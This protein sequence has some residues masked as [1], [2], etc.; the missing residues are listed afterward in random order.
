[1]TIT[2][3]LINVCEK[4]RQK[5]F[6]SEENVKQEIVEQ[7]LFSLGW[8]V[9][10]VSIVAREFAM[11][12]R[13]VDYALFHPPKKPLIFIEV[14][15]VGLSGGADRQLFEYAFHLGVPMAILTDG[16]EWSFYL[17]AQQGR[18]DERRVYKL[19]LLERSIEEAAYRLERYLSYNSICSGQALKNA[20][21]DYENVTRDRDIQATLPKAWIAL[22][23][24]KDSLVLELLADKV[25]DLCGYKPNVAI[26]ETFLKEQAKDVN[27]ERNLETM[28]TILRQKKLKNDSK[29]NIQGD[30]NQSENTE[31]QTVDLQHSENSES[32]LD[33]RDIYNKCIQKIELL[34]KIN[35]VRKG[36]K[37]C[38][39][40]DQE[41]GFSLCI[42]KIYKEKLGNKYWFA[43][44][45]K[46]ENYLKN[47]KDS[48]VVYICGNE[49][50]IFLIPLTVIQNYK[51]NLS[52]S[53]KGYWHIHIHERA[54][55][56]YWKIPK[57]NQ[58]VDIEKYRI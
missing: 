47:F 2:N 34:F 30:A 54:G 8:N 58:Q 7:A 52:T 50:N 31:R 11:E 40:L 17:P 16:R 37:N 3:L 6:V 49:N 9:F 18:Y 10:D 45:P 24:D 19:D 32:L 43:F 12:N 20:Q 26:C 41:K 28:P 56:F 44:Y 36:Q 39:T 4:L 5:K 42:S 33:Y 29:T 15:N 22:L 1:M 55:S 46:Q 14:K 51:N 13:R 21:S 25:E 57:N 38:Q 23:Q 48:C 35:L 53:E 27:L